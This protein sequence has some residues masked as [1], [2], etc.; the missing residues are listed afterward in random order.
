MKHPEARFNPTRSRCQR[1]IALR[2][3][4]HDAH[5]A[6]EM[7]RTNEDI[8]EVPDVSL[9]VAMPALLSHMIA[10]MATKIEARSYGHELV[11]GDDG[12]FHTRPLDDETVATAQRVRAWRHEVEER[13]E[14]RRLTMRQLPYR[15]RQRANARRMVGRGTPV[16]DG[17]QAS[18][19]AT[20]RAA[21]AAI[22]GG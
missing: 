9:P 15:Q 1:E 13:L 22:F 14:M 11:I 16:K 7:V 20:A 19:E 6:I 21:G 8:H 18:P 3:R 12:G 2:L 5:D 4:G 17:G 10:R